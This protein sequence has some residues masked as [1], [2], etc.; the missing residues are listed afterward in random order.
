MHRSI[1]GVLCNNVTVPDKNDWYFS[2]HNDWYFLKVDPR[3]L[4]SPL[5]LILM[6]HGPTRYPHPGQV[7]IARLS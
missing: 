4:E 5:L 2:F 7:F 1:T 6:D 3:R